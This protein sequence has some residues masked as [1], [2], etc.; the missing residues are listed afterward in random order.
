MNNTGLDNSRNTFPDSISV[1]TL[2]NVAKSMKRI[3]TFGM[4]PTTFQVQLLLLQCPIN[5]MQTIHWSV[6]TKVKQF[7][8]RNILGTLAPSHVPP[9]LSLSPSHCHSICFYAINLDYSMM[10]GQLPGRSTAT[11]KKRSIHVH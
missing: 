2:L 6:L 5:L 9:P 4:K 7:L 11:G 3:R 1:K 10:H 8:H